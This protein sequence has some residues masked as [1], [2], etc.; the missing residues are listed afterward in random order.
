MEGEED[1][2]DYDAEEGAKVE[3]AE[4]EAPD[5]GDL[6]DDSVDASVGAESQELCKLRPGVLHVSGVQRLTRSHL[7]EVLK[8]A[9]MPVFNKLEWISDEEVLMMFTSP[10]SAIT[11]L[12]GV[13]RGFAEI[14]E[15]SAAGNPGLWRARRGMLE[16]RQAN[17]SHTP[18]PGFKRHHRAGRQTREFRDWASTQGQKRS[19]DDAWAEDDME[20]QPSKRARLDDV[21]NKGFELLEQMAKQDQLILTKEEPLQDDFWADTEGRDSDFVQG[22]FHPPQE[23]H[24]DDGREDERG[25]NSWRAQD[26]GGWWQESQWDTGWSSSRRRRQESWYVHDDRS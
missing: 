7:Q 22:T 2:A 11:V 23:P 13:E 21:G 18:A 12:M 9:K 14:T 17:A 3:P 20:R 19:A 6:I 16:F 4:R 26:R 15:D 25:H 10:E 24:R 8:A 1:G 5:Y